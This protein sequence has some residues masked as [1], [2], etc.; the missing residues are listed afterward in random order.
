[1]KALAKPDPLYLDEADLAQRI[2]LPIEDW[3]AVATV[4]ERAGMPLKD[5]LFGRRYWPA[6]KA[7]FDRRAGLTNAA[8]C[9]Q[10]DGLENFDVRPR[11]GKRSNTRSTHNQA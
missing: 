5:T 2:G 9:S 6:V 4:L 10:P 7:Y 11:G 1:M 3:R 8:I